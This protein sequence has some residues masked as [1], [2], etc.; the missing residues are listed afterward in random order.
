MYIQGRR[1]LYGQYSFGCTTFLL[2]PFLDGGFNRASLLINKILN[3]THDI[4]ANYLCTYVIARIYTHVG[5]LVL[6]A[7][8]GGPLRFCSLVMMIQGVTSIEGRQLPP[9]PLQTF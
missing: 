4:N 9:H 8:F 7:F 1:K 6:Y 2:F 3:Y 5:L